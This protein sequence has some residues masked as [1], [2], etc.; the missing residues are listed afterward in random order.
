MTH[1]IK[2]GAKFQ[3]APKQAIDIHQTLP[4]GTYVVKFDEMRSSFYLEVIEDFVLTGKVYGDTTKHA[5][6]IFRTFERRDSST[7]VLLN[8]EKGS[9]K[10]LLAKTLSVMG[11]DKGMPTLVI[12]QA[13]F[14]EAFNT[15]M[16]MINQPKIVLFDEFEK[17]Y[18]REQQEK[19][20]TLLDGVYPSKTMFV[21][22]CNDKYRVNNMMLNRPGR[23]FYRI[24]YS[25]LDAAFIREYADD[26]LINKTHIDSLARLSSLF[27]QFNFDML[28]AIV[29]EMNRY[30]ESPQEAMTI[31]NARPEQNEDTIYNVQL[32][33]EGVDLDPAKFILASPKWQGNPLMPE[34][35]EIQIAYRNAANNIFRSEGWLYV[36]F[37]AGDLVGIDDQTGALTFA[38]ADG[39]AVTLTRQRATNPTYYHVAY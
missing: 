33:F 24:E 20:L 36:R 18:E 28:K 15:F 29:E 4:V 25:G 1:F 5:D 31:L 22:T 10:T 37:Q 17:V 9:G 26:N 11:R 34:D 6:R 30:D 32:Q 14:G 27:T 3:V 21:L 2:D 13:W 7:G 39:Y 38:N 19:M 35:D 8:G 16:Q 12:N 23:I